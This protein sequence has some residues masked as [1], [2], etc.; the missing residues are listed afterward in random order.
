VIRITVLLLLLSVVSLRAQT[1]DEI[2]SRTDKRTAMERAQQLYAN[3]QNDSL[4]AALLLQWLN[5][6]PK[7]TAA[8]SMLSEIHR[9]SG[10]TVSASRAR[11]HLDKNKTNADPRLLTIR[12][13]Q[14]R[15]GTY[16]V[17]LPKRLDSGAVY[18]AILVLH[19]NSNNADLMINW[20]RTLAMDSV[21]FIVP[22]AP[23]TKHIDALN[24]HTE[25]YSASGEGLGLPDSLM[26]DVVTLSASWYMS[27]LADARKRLP[28]AARKPLIVGFSQ[29][30]FY[31]Y[32]LATRNPQDVAGVVSICASM[33]DYG[34]VKEKLP[35]LRSNAIPVLITHGV[36]DSVVPYSTAERIA[37]WLKEAGV[38]HEL[39]QFDGG[40]WPS[41]EV[42]LKVRDWLVARLR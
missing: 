20:A 22:E 37:S 36:H 21:I 17:L 38:A 15:Y 10:D 35:L 16:K 42:T 12:A 40:H 19:G 7:D 39:I 29:G 34:K 1:L 24:T 14:R 11:G 30:G 4:A 6:V 8:L 33:W 3:K 9:R 26:A 18:P 5:V 41:V 32:V 23:Y 25:R 31:S 13:E 2:L 28:I 27:T